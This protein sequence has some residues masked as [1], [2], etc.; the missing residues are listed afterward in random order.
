[1]KDN[2]M[3]YVKSSIKKFW[4]LKRLPVKEKIQLFPKRDD[5]L[6]NMRDSPWLFLWMDIEHL[7]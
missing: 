5:P 4:S 2:T 1:M 6:Q 7:I 3:N